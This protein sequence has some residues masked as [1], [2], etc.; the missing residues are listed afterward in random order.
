MNFSNMRTFICA[1]FAGLIVFS[2]LGFYSVTMAEE[3]GFYAH[4]KLNRLAV[5]TLPPEMMPLFKKEIE[6]LSTHAVDPD[7]RRY[8]TPFEGPRHYIDLDVYGEFP[9]D[10]LPRQWNKALAKFSSVKI[11]DHCSGAEVP[12][13]H[14][15]YFPYIHFDEEVQNKNKAYGEFDNLLAMNYQ[16]FFDPRV[17][18]DFYRPPWKYPLSDWPEKKAVFSCSGVDCCEILITDHISKYGIITYYLP[19]IQRQLTRAM[20]NGD[21]ARILRHAADIGHYIGDAHVPLHT[22]V[23]Y[24]GQLTGQTGI[25][26]FWESRIPELFAEDFDLIVG[27]AEYIEDKEDFFWDVVLY[28]HQKVDSVLSIEQRLRDSFPEDAQ[29]CFEDRLQQTIQQPCREFA[30]AYEREMNGMV[31][32]QMRKTIYAI[33][34]SWYTAWVDAGKPDLGEHVATD[35]SHQIES[36]SLRRV[37]QRGSIYGR[38]QVNE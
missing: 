30:L 4:R 12:D 24:N 29:M 2:S 18:G 27:K 7:R 23:N 22:T 21:K 15:I 31:E 32:R 9:Y 37:Y 16:E 3:W 25:H 35:Q 26:A 6:Y 33:G 14:L 5:F 17:P 34:S 11:I 19:I 28:T 1:I 8:A 20:R 10:N 38:E 36:D 13:T